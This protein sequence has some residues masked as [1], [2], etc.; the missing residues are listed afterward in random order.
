MRHTLNTTWTS[1]ETSYLEW[2][3]SLL[4]ATW[5]PW[6]RWTL[7]KEETV[8]SYLVSIS[9]STKTSEHGSSRSILILNLSSRILGWNTSPPK[10]LMTFLT[11]CS[12]PFLR[13]WLTRKGKL[14]RVLVTLILSTQEQGASTK[15]D[16]CWRVYILLRKRIQ[17]VMLF[18]DNFKLEG[19]TSRKIYHF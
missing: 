16:P 8:L 2:K 1:T 14:L 7:P 3:T 10:C 4:T 15:E 17:E 19:Q 18:L 5:Q 12:T 11:L 13:E 6:E 9:W